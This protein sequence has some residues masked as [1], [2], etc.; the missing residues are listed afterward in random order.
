M[1]VDSI[2]LTLTSGKGGAGAVS[3]HKEKFILKGGPDGGDGGRGGDIVFVVDANT[4]T[5]S[6]FRGQKKIKAKG[7][8]SGDIRNRAGKKGE[9]T[10]IKVPPGTQVF[11]KESGELL[12]D[13]VKEGESEVFLKGGRGGLGNARFKSSTNQRPTHA[14]PGES[15]KSQEVRLELKLIAD[16]GLVGFPNVGKSTLISA[17]SSA[18]PE[19]ANYEF[20]T[21][22]PKLGVV[23]GKDFRSFVMA[24][25]PGII[26]GASD[27]KGLGLDF[28]RHIE[29]TR[30]LL[31]M[32]DCANYR[33]L[34]N[35]FKALQNE[36]EKYS[37]QL[38]KRE[39]AIAIT[40][41]DAYYGENITKDIENFLKDIG[42]MPNMSAELHDKILPGFYS[43]KEGI[44][45]GV[46]QFVLPISSVTKFNLEPLSYELLKMADR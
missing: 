18:T 5:L 19:I 7:G 12:L 21:L 25:I 32:I 22:T 2:E 8:Q 43:A 45:E 24:D 26:D 31:F 39:Y 28:L 29:R 30:V 37:L 38:A 17:L 4:N 3:F 41:C 27:G 34:T 15:G 6:H 35:Q 16:V 9:S 36:L 11:S 10:Y 14:Q 46:P 13:L 33:T 1:F 23:N 40:R 44:F 42:L 20:T